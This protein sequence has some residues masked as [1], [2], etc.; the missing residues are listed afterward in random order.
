MPPQANALDNL[1]AINRLVAL[2]Y[3]PDAPR[4]TLTVAAFVL[5]SIGE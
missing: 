1:F 5:K 2:L 3:S 4:A